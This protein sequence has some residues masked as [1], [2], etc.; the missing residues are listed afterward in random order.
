MKNLKA[1]RGL[2]HVEVA[3]A[4]T[5]ALP[6]YP[7]PYDVV[8]VAQD[9]GLDVTGHRSKP[10]NALLF[11]WADMILVMESYMRDEIE[12]VWPEKDAD[13]IFLLSSFAPGSNSSGDIDD[14]Y[15]SSSDDFER[16]F[17]RIEA[18]IQGLL[19]ALSSENGLSPEE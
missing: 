9:R 13:K 11:D 7:A 15:G 1:A 12:L 18:S 6:D 5:G 14:P 19:D 4:G 3:S 16:C 17:D 8:E 2:E 10:L